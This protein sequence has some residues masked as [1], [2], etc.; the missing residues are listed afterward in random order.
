MDPEAVETHNNPLSAWTEKVL[1]VWFESSWNCSPSILDLE[2]A[3]CPSI[4]SEMPQT[5]L[6]PQFCGGI[7]RFAW[8]SESSSGS[9]TRHSTW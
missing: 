8:N 6:K 1:S 5:L 7:G 2:W 9:P 4:V 3:F